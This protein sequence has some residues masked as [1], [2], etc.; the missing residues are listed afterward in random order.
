MSQRLFVFVQ[1]EFP[2]ILGP[3]DGRYLLRPHADGEPERVVVIDTLPSRALGTRQEPGA[4]TSLLG[5]LLSGADHAVAPEPDPEQVVITRVTVIDPV[6]LSAESQARAWLEDMDAQHE[7]QGT[8][9]VVNRVLHFH[10]IAAADA[11]VHEISPAQAIAL[12]A[13][14]GEG[15]QVAD[16]RWLHAQELE[17]GS[18]ARGPL[19]RLRGRRARATA[20][21]PQERM[22]QLLGARGTALLCEDL[23]LRARLD[24][25]H[26]R[27]A[28]ATLELDRA[29]AMAV[30][31]LQAEKRQDL[32]IRLAELEQLHVGVAEAA[33]AVLAGVPSAPD[34]DVLTHALE[35]LEAALRARS[36]TGFRR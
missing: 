26:E 7:L 34:A 36:V 19:G 23:T 12:R 6:S 15:E 22:A 10:R 24:L 31:E 16:G 21:R 1:M 2:W 13:G 20:L 30:R 18:S 29:M 4:R 8:A 9:V 14:W 5:R 35:R 17:H 33:A 25:D 32:A 11:Y 28:H 27:L 3:A